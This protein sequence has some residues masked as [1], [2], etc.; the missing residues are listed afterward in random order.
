[1]IEEENLTPHIV[2]NQIKS[3]LEPEK[4]SSI[5]EKLKTFAVFD[6]AEKIAEI[7]L[8]PNS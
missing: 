1:M 8:N 5:S 4:L 3:L 6:A 7:L 2:I